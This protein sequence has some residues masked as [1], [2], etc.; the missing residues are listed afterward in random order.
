MKISQS[1]KSDLHSIMNIVID[2]QVYLASQKIDTIKPDNILI[3]ETVGYEMSEPID[4]C[5]QLGEKERDC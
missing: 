4:V 1:S 3:G 5:I 2:A